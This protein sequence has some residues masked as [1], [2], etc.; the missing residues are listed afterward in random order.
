V[1]VVDYERRHLEGIV[2]LCREEGWPS[3]PEDRLRADRV[4]RAPGVT[5][6]VAVEGEAVIGFA[7]LQ[8]DGEI[9]AHLSNIVVA[10]RHRRTGIGRALLQVG[11]ERAGGRRLDLITDSAHSFYEALDHRR[12]AGYRLYPPFDEPGRTQP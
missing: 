1:E 11:F 3:F 12:L 2:A 8:S 5:S 4:L 10:R 6:V 7:Y 9:Q